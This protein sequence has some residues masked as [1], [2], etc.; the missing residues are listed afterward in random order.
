MTF[1]IG[2]EVQSNYS[3]NKYIVTGYSTDDPN[4]LLC[5]NGDHIQADKVH[6]TGRHFDEV[7]EIL[8]KSSIKTI[9]EVRA[10]KDYGDVYTMKEF[11]NKVLDGDFNMN[12]GIGR[13]HDGYNEIEDKSVFY[14]NVN[15]LPNYPYVRWYNE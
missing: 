2:D 1:N 9:D 8:K 15:E 7:N 5:F 11:I 13:L 6:A 4:I 12:F 10:E 3:K 14:T